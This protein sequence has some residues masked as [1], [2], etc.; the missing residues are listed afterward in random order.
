[1]SA[2]TPTEIAGP[3]PSAAPTEAVGQTGGGERPTAQSTSGPGDGTPA[4]RNCGTPLQPGQDWC[5]QCGAGAPGSLQSG[6]PSWRSATTLLLATAVLVL[7]AAAAGYAALDKSGPAK[8]PVHVITVAQAPA[9]TG[10]ASPGGTAP[11]ATPP[12]TTTPSPT[13]TGGAS[14]P[15]S[16]KP[17]GTSANPPKIPLTAPT[18]KALVK[19]PATT[20]NKGSPGAGA[21]K[22]TGESTPGSGEG[23]GGAEASQQAVLLDT[24][25]ASTYNP[26]SYPESEFGDPSLAIDGEAGTAWT[27]RVNP[28]VAPKMAEG[29][30]IDLKSPHKVAAIKLTS[31]PGMTVQVYGANGSAPPN[32]ITDPAWKGLSAA[33]EVKKKTTNIKLHD[34]NRGFR[35]FVLWIS[36]APASAVGTPQAPGHVSVDE[37]ELFPAK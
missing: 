22:G 13:P 27:A 7:G 17:L 29:I 16:V 35:F 26:Y 14:A 21:G 12:P 36:K 23:A 1:V 20:K 32:S 25:A 24:N 11:P 31:T 5:L 37:L 33:R 3:T 30:V 28:A 2:P 10:A 4:C 9:G 6:G 15:S 19:A 18:P 34:A 8:P